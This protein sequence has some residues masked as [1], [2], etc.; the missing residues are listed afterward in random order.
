MPSTSRDRRGR[1]RG[2]V[3]GGL[4]ARPA[5]STGDT[6]GDTASD[7]TDIA[8]RTALRRSGCRRAPVTVQTTPRTSTSASGS[9]APATTARSPSRISRD[10]TRHGCCAGNSG[11]MSTANRGSAATSA[12]SRR[13][14][15][16]RRTRRSSE[17]LDGAGSTVELAVGLGLASPSVDPFSGTAGCRRRIWSPGTGR[18]SGTAPG[19]P[20]LVV[21]R[22]A[23]YQTQTD[24]DTTRSISSRK[25]EHIDSNR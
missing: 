12:P 23:Q 11:A 4:G 21:L 9:T 22:S 5:A 13:S 8:E 16:R 17:H 7:S 18:G 24:N 19:I 20:T 25:Y 10:R 3:R 14:H 15:R 1:R 2:G 6:T